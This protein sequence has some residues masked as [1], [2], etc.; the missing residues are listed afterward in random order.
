MIP[1]LSIIRGSEKLTQLP[2]VTQQVAEL[3]F[4]PKS[5]QP[6]NL[7]TAFYDANYIYNFPLPP[8][9]INKIIGEVE[10]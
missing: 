4:Q 9:S 2:K 6:K 8:K 7:W 3:G 1:I 10:S 5:V